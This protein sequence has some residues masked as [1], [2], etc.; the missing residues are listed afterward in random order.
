M[1]R[2][3]NGVT[4][5]ELRESVAEGSSLAGGP[6]ASRSYLVPNWS[7]RFAVA[8]AL[9]G[10][11]SYSGGAITHLPGDPY[12]DST[13]LLATDVAIRGVGRFMPAGAGTPLSF[14]S[15]VVT[16]QYGTPGYASAYANSANN[17]DPM[18][19]MIYASQSIDSAT[20]VIELGAGTVRLGDGASGAPGTYLARSQGIFVGLVNMN[21]TLYKLP[22]MIPYDS[23]L[24]VGNVNSAPIFGCAVGTLM[25]MGFNTQEDFD[26]AGNSMQTVNV[27]F[28]HRPIAPHDQILHPYNPAKG[29]VQMTRNGVSVLQYFDLNSLIPSAYRGS[30]I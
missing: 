26:S 10:L 22:Y 16:C 14:E 6:R 19:P 27:S 21:L 23:R 2:I 30:S 11:T 20:Q 7:D 25:L 13:N 17:F 9:L 3:I 18:M 12:P 29:W 28:Q 15:A 24:R 8:N 5:Y 1:P 4:V